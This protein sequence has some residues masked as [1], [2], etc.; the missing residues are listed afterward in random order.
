MEQ[1]GR[2]GR[3]GIALLHEKASILL[4]Q[5]HWAERV[6]IGV[7]LIMLLSDSAIYTTDESGISNF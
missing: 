4:T 3:N 1:K 6:D 2:K 5:N 7:L